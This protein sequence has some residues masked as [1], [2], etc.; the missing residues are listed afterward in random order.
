MKH[1]RRQDILTAAMQLFAKKGFRGT[2]TRDL[3]AQAGVNE[4]IIFRHFS[5]KEELYSAILEHKA[6]ENRD[7]RSD[8]I[9]Q[10]ATGTD[11]VKFFQAVGRT[12]L[13]RHARDATFMRLLLFSALEGHELSQM[14]VANMAARN[15]NPLANYIKRRIDEGA[16]RPMNPELAARGLFGMFASF[17]L[18]QE[19]FG[20][21][22]TQAY[23]RDEVVRTFVSIFLSGI[24]KE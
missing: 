12:F 19:V 13:E 8:E 2:T 1:E 21:K 20:Q 17:V 15:P 14:F 22:E 11:D 10:L 3:A 23:D 24:S 18:W 7:A 9:D 4:A 16:F 6:C 5:T